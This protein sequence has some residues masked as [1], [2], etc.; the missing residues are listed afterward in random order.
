MNFFMKYSSCKFKS[1]LLVSSV[2]CVSQE[3]HGP[4]QT[5]KMPGG[6]L[7]SGS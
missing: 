6:H 4:A 3:A 1:F 5:A 2:I 7:P